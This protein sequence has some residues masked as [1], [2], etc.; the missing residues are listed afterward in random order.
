MPRR[1]W[2]ATVAAMGLAL[3]FASSGVAAPKAAT[4]TSRE[5]QTKLD[6]ARWRSLLDLAPLRIV[7]P[8]E[9]AHMIVFFDPNCPW[10][11]QL[12]NWLYGPGGAGIATAW[13]PVTYMS[14]T[15]TARAA[16]ILRAA[17]AEKALAENFSSY[18]A[19][20]GTG[21]IQPVLEVTP[22]EQARFSRYIATWST[23]G[24]ATPLIVYL[25]KDGATYSQVGLPTRGDFM[26]L[27][28][29]LPSS[30]LSSFPA[31]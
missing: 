16:A 24:A 6:N 10:C 22:Q 20:S 31:P 12:W 1:L 9:L 7:R 19:A 25:G 27:L 28:S 13:V 8:G 4:N 21:A 18:D 29:E 17:D 3:V 26:K 14:G 23:L 11:A 30:S 15:S 5:G 2:I